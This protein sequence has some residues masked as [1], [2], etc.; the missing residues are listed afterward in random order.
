MKIKFLSL[1]FAG[2]FLTACN[3]NTSNNNGFKNPS[4]NKV[5]NIQDEQP[6]TGD[7]QLSQEDYQ[8]ALD[9]FKKIN[10][11]FLVESSK[12]DGVITTKSG[13]RYKII[14]KGNGKKPTPTD[15]VTVKYT[16]SL[17]DG[18]VFDSTDKHGKPATFPLNQ[19]I[20]GWIEGLQLMNEGSTYTLIIPP[21]LAYGDV[22][23][24]SIPPNSVLIFNVELLKVET[25][26]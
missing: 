16:G 23:V 14:N 6:E 20:P 11:A 19:V 3:L 10:Q 8:A 1:I 15:I 2:L 24:G 13:L 9:N 26:K 5:T 21:E 4:E 12:Q 7:K 17:I 22:P 25:G 18:T